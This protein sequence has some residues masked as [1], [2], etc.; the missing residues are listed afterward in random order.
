MEKSNIIETTEEKPSLTLE[1]E[2][3]RSELT[4]P[5]ADILDEFF[6]KGEEDRGRRVSMKV[7]QLITKTSDPVIKRIL[8]DFGELLDICS[9]EERGID[10]I[11]T[12]AKQLSQIKTNKE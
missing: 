5:M 2:K 7:N 6:G 1:Q 4:L 11:L 10:S 12:K 8:K 3:F 9:D